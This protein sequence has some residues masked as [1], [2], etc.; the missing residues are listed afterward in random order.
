MEVPRSLHLQGAGNQRAARPGDQVAVGEGVVRLGQRVGVAAGDHVIG[1]AFHGLL[2]R[3]QGR[4][5]GLDGLLIV[6]L[7]RTSA[8]SP[9]SAPDRSTS[10]TS[11]QEGTGK[12]GPSSEM[13]KL[14]AQARREVVADIEADLLLELVDGL[15]GSRRRALLHAGHFVDDGRRALHHER[16][17]QGGI[18]RNVIERAH[19]RRIGQPGGDPGAGAV[20]IHRGAGFHLALDVLLFGHEVTDAGVCGPRVQPRK[21][22]AQQKPGACRGKRRRCGHRTACPGSCRMPSRERRPCSSTDAFA[23]P[24]TTSPGRVTT[25]AGIPCCFR[26]SAKPSRLLSARNTGASTSTVG[27]GDRRDHDFVAQ[28]FAGG[29]QLFDHRLDVG[30]PAGPPCAQLGAFRELLAEHRLGFAEILR[31]VRNAGEERNVRRAGASAA[32]CRSAAPACGSSAG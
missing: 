13:R 20:E 15:P 16:R 10:A 31:Q 27:A 28:V 29:A 25:A 7:R 8:G 12:G 14:A 4:A 11:F 17:D 24:N 19:R 18:G 5:A 26:N 32:R 6:R 30:R 9:A 2:R 21:I 3:A 22:G 1:A 23:G